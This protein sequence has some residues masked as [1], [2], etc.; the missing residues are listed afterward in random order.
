MPDI[1]PSVTSEREHLPPSLEP[2]LLM[3]LL[4]F[5]PGLLIVILPRERLT[6]LLGPVIGSMI[7]F[8]TIGLIMLWRTERAHRQKRDREPGDPRDIAE[9]SDL[10][11]YEA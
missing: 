3:C 4:A 8:L 7:M 2:W 10:R 11:R 6:P 5:I 9:R 1:E